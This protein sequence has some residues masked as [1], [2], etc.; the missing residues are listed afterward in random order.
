MLLIYIVS[1]VTFAR[2]RQNGVFVRETVKPEILTALWS[3]SFARVGFGCR[4]GG[5]LWDAGAR[6]VQVS[7]SAGWL[8]GENDLEIR[9]CTSAAH[10]CEPWALPRWK[11]P[12]S[13]C[14]SDECPPG[15]Q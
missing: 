11:F 12:V 9:T 5:G 3:G 4:A 10:V 13:H 1:W 6:T 7:H 8:G 14:N 15:M 2:Q